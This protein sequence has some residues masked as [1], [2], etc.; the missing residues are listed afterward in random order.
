MSP[1]KSSQARKGWWTAARIS[2]IYLLVAGIWLYVADG[3]MAQLASRPHLLA[4]LRPYQGWIFI[5]LTALL[6]FRMIGNAL[7]APRVEQP[8]GYR[9]DDRSRLAGEPLF[10]S[11]W[12]GLSTPVL[13]FL[14]LAGA[15]GGMGYLVYAYQRDSLQREKQNELLAIADTKVDQISSWLTERRRDVQFIARDP[16]VAQ[17]IKCWFTGE[18][19]AGGNSAQRLLAWLTNLRETNGY[20]AVALLDDRGEVRLG[21]GAYHL[22]PDGQALALQAMQAGRVIVSD[23]HQRPETAEGGSEIDILAP[24]HCGSEG[25]GPPVGALYLQIDPGQYLFPV[26]QTWPTSSPS[27]ETLLV[28][29]EGNDVLYLNELRHQKN[30]ALR[31]RL[32]MTDARLP[33]AMA[34]GGQEGIVEGLDYRQVPVIAALRRVPDTAWFLIA[35][36]DADEVYSPVRTMMLFV[37]TLTAVLIVGAG[38][39]ASMWWRQQHA[40]FL[41]NYYQGQLER[42]AL[43]QQAESAR[44][45]NEARLHAIA[46]AVPDV[47]MLIDEDGRYLEILTSQP[48]LLY[49]APAA[50]K[51][52]LVSEVL[53]AEAANRVLEAVNRTL[54][55]GE[56][57]VVEYDLWISKIGKRRFETRTAPIQAPGTANPA[58]VLLARDITQR[59]LTEEKLRHAQKMEA[60]GQ[61]TG[62]V[63]HDFNNL[64]AIVIGNLELL[65]EQLAARPD[66]RDLVH[67]AFTAADRGATLT[68]RLLAYSRQQPL[69]PKPINLNELVTGMTDLF[70]RTLG[71]SIQIKT[72]LAD[73]LQLTLI[74][75]VQFET[76]LL[77]LVLNAR[78]AMPRGGELTI[79]TANRWLD[80]EQAGNPL[81]PAPTGQYIMLAVTDTGVGMIPA[82]LER[83]FEPFFTTKEVGKGSGLGLSMVY[84]FVSQSGGCVNISS[85]PGEGTTVTILLPS[86]PPVESPK[87]A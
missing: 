3:L 38:L 30:T 9:L 78:D 83:A 84:G 68:Q 14:L 20:R 55:T 46:N 21:A 27:A 24:L 18:T 64:L 70:K 1:S 44:R 58:V 39:G 67:R 49:T 45:E 47:L 10:P 12:S 82:A 62:G 65:D 69:Q 23:L 43:L 80:G 53:P 7:T 29:Q 22:D 87:P 16:F 19:G 54:A 71:A 41:A 2:L 75:P 76:A 13:I 8:A 31:L 77:N 32:P 25:G 36:V 57:Q 51:G 81:Y 17:E 86:G 15:I 6:I 56:I 59:Q 85:A 33:A 73:D 66:L 40:I 72:A 48:E 35:K 61:L 79:T 52:R 28:R 50:L 34:V 63:A 60:I 74:D 5:V 42:Q 26:L 37:A 11:S 4:I